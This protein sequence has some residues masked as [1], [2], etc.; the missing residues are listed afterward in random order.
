LNASKYLDT[1][2]NGNRNSIRPD[3]QRP[4]L[5]SNSKSQK[6]SKEESKQPK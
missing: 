6:D 5:S 3:K 1:D 2:E 4:D